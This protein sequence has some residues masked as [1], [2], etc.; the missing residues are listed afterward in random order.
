[1]LAHWDRGVKVVNAKHACCKEDSWFKRQTARL[2][3]VQLAC[4]TQHPAGARARLGGA[5]FSPELTQAVQDRLILDGIGHFQ[6]TRVQTEIDGMAQDLQT[7]VD[8]ATVAERS[9]RSLLVE[10]GF[11]T[12]E[13]VA[14]DGGFDG[15]PVRVFL[16]LHWSERLGFYL[17]MIAVSVLTVAVPWP[18]IRARRPA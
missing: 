2:P 15:A 10:A 5:H 17:S 12:L 13:V 4:R 6:L 8:L 11:G 18:L 9:S 1:M 3:G 14:P 16:P 7:E